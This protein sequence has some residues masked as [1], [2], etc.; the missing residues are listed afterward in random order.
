MSKGTSIA[1]FTLLGV[2][3]AGCLA[4]GRASARIACDGPYQIVRGQAIATPYCQDAYVAQVARQYGIAVTA[5]EIRSNP[6]TKGRVC[7]AIGNDN[8]VQTACAAFRDDYRR[9]GY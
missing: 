4:S 5:E 3:M 9:R 6:G 2:V 1:V 7:R 8:R